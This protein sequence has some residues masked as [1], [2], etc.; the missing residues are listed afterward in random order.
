[1]TLDD[2][3]L[4]IYDLIHALNKHDLE[5]IIGFYALDYEGSDV[6]QAG[7]QR[8]IEAVRKSLT[9]CFEAFPDL[10][11]AVERTV[12]ETNCVAL[13]WTAVGTHHGIFMKIPPTGRKVKLR[14]VSLL[15][16]KDGKVVHA[17]RIW[18]L[19]GLLRDVGLLPEL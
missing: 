18:D 14:G 17:Q 16:L 4:L 3:Q 19:A 2:T 5:R 7:S 11:F 12:I 15:I 1:M 8:G 10:Y 6:A 13:F 9:R